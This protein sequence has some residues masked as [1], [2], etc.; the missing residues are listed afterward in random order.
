[1]SKER[2]QP[3][4]IYG[5]TDREQLWDRITDGRFNAIIADEQTAIH[6]IELST[7]NYG[8]FL[9]VAT[10]RGAGDKRA[11]VAFFGL[12]YHEHRERWITEEW[13]WYRANEFPGVLKRQV[14]KEEAQEVLCERRAAIAG[15]ASQQTQSK[16]GKLFEMVADLTDDDGAISEMEDMGDD[17]ADWLSDGLE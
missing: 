11:C 10:S 15:Y 17:L 4:E 3:Q 12:G 6:Q 1:M 16:R 13:F 2:P 9:F 5:F 7:N 14:S 8:E